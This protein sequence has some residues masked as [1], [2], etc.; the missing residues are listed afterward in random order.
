[1]LI[2]NKWEQLWEYGEGLHRHCLLPY[3]F[4]ECIYVHDKIYSN[5]INKWKRH[6]FHKPIDVIK[7][8]LH[9]W[10]KQTKSGG[11]KIDSNRMSLK[12]KGKC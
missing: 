7:L 1:M 9:G 3:P 4:Y 11:N 10:K 5:Q 6:F 12:Y 2:I 8:Q